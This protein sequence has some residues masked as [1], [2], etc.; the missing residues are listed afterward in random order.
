[1]MRKKYVSLHHIRN[2]HDITMNTDV[3]FLHLLQ[4]GLLLALKEQG[5]L[6]ELQYRN[7][8]DRLNTQIHKWSRKQ[9][10]KE[11]SCR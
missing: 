6:D 11:E 3:E 7:A 1:M 5:C 9:M 4:Q 2:D 10:N 8:V